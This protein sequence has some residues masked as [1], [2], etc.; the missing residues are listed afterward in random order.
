MEKDSDDRECAICKDDMH[1]PAFS[2]EDLAVPDT[3]HRLSCHH[4]FH[5]SCLLTFFR[6]NS[7]VA[8]PLCRNGAHEPISARHGNFT[9]TVTENDVEDEEDDPW[10]EMAADLRVYRSASTILQ[11]RKALKEN[12]KIYNTFKCKLKQEKKKC[13][14]KALHKF[15]EE[16]RP[17]YRSIQN[18]LKSAS[19]VVYNAEKESF[20]ADKGADAYHARSWTEIHEL[21]GKTGACKDESFD[22][23]R[24][25]D[26]WNSSFWYA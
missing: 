14:Q 15:R 11:A 6:S 23:S 18:N 24:K 21:I 17:E 25:N 7:K 3:V 10:A 2:V 19:L 4:A 13:I 20:I 26:P 12:I 1:T 22:V 8:C 16:Y 9:F 5:S